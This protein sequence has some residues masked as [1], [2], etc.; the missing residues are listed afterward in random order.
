VERT[1]CGDAFATAFVAALHCDKSVEEAMRWGTANSA[2]VLG[3]VGPQKGLLK[4]DEMMK[5]LK[6][7]PEK[8]KKI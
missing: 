7:F 6:R 4:H 2:S 8:P 3:F 1:G 5:F